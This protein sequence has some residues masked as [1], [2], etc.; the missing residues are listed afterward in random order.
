VPPLR[1]RL[2]DVPAL[3]RF[4]LA[5]YADRFGTGP[6][7]T[8]EALDARL[9]AHTWPGN[10]R[11]L[12]NLVESLVALS[13]DG[14]I[15]ESLLPN[16]G[17]TAAARGAG[18]RERVEAYE[19]GVLVATLRACGGNRSEAARRLQISRATLHEK[20]NK[21]SLGGRDE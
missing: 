2:D 8:S 12:E 7:R 17:P 14:R 9:Q 6:L 11:E 5:R 20:L 13:H 3:F 1:E 21:Y 19:R 10:V 18:L 15:D 16:A 4:F